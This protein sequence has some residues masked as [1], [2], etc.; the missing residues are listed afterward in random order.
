MAT[1][2]YLTFN[3]SRA[4]VYMMFKLTVRRELEWGDLERLCNDL[5]LSEA[6]GVPRVRALADALEKSSADLFIA[7]A[8]SFRIPFVDARKIIFH[9]LAGVKDAELKA[10]CESLFPLLI[11]NKD[12]VCRIPLAVAL[13]TQIATSSQWISQ[14]LANGRAQA[15]FL[16]FFVPSVSC[17]FLMFGMDVVVK[18]ITDARGRILLAVALLLYATGCLCLRRLALHSK[19][20]VLHRSIE[21]VSGRALFLRSLLLTVEGPGRFLEGLNHTMSRLPAPKWQGLSH[22]ARF[23]LLSPPESEAK[24]VFNNSE[25]TFLNSVNAGCLRVSAEERRNWIE[26][27]HAILLDS[28]QAALARR[29]AS[30]NLQLLIVMAIF[31]LPALFLIL[32]LSGTTP[33][34]GTLV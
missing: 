9:A 11:R 26:R 12:G 15:M 23:A 6:R 19:N 16:I 2:K 13:L 30:L 18:N 25:L 22:S 34:P 21:F 3:D 5:V 32:W 8:P 14:Q 28:M 24:H 20:L 10:T 29:V 4:R 27:S 31:F 7:L 33:D 17:I 1:E